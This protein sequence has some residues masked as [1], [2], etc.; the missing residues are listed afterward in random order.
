[1]AR[2]SFKTRRSLT[3]SSTAC[4]NASAGICPKQSLMSVSTTQRLPRQDSSMSTCK[5]SR[6]SSPGRNPKLHGR[7]PASNTGSRTIRAAACTIRS[8]TA[9][10]DNGLRSPALP[11]LGI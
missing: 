11:G 9:G 1:M 5:A 4:I 3:R 7:K 10:T 8:D 2:S 6:G